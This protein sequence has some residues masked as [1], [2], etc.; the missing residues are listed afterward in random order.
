MFYIESNYYVFLC[1]CACVCVCLC[2]CM[3]GGGGGCV[4]VRVCVCVCVCA[5]VCVYQGCRIGAMTPFTAPGN[6]SGRRCFFGATIITYI[7]MYYNYIQGVKPVVGT[8]L[9]APAKLIFNTPGV[10]VCVCVCLFTE[11][12]TL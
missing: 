8:E 5:C 12:Q 1:V 9:L 11:S 2:V 6:A 10:C 4:H 7:Y 3:W